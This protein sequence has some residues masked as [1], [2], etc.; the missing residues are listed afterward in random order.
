MPSDNATQ[1]KRKRKGKARRIVPCEIRSA[2]CRRLENC[3]FSL[4]LLR[5]SWAKLQSELAGVRINDLLENLHRG[6]LAIGFVDLVKLEDN[7]LLSGSEKMEQDT[8]L[9]LIRLPVPLAQVYS[10]ARGAKGVRERYDNAYYSFEVLI[11]LASSTAIAAYVD[12]V[13]QGEPR[14]ETIE[15]LVPHLAPPALV[16]WL[17]FLRALARHFGTRPDAVSHPAGFT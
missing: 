13:G 6:K 2:S 16:H 17:G 15:P 10:P 9:A 8:D 4:S 11:K 3:D 12:G 7:R 14:L 5:S 1:F